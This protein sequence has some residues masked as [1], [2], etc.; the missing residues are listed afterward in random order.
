MDLCLPPFAPDPHTAT[1]MP[2]RSVY[3]VETKPCDRPSEELPL[4]LRELLC[5]CICSKGR[6]IL[7][8]AYISLWGTISEA[9][10][11][12]FWAKYVRRAWNN[13]KESVELYSLFTGQT[14]A[15]TVQ[16]RFQCSWLDSS[17]DL[18]E[19]QVYIPSNPIKEK[20]FPHTHT[21]LHTPFTL[22]STCSIFVS[23]ILDMLVKVR[24]ICFWSVG[25]ISL[26]FTNTIHFA[27]FFFTKMISY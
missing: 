15:S 2:L 22:V 25:W 10:C 14:F 27:T 23:F 9:V 7:A 20:R 3:A 11:V 19:G 6:Q 21:H 17:R 24:L 18:E 12:C 1:F 26:W 8:P 5:D 13:C 4:D 16:I